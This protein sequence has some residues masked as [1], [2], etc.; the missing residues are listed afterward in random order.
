MGES[1]YDKFQRSRPTYRRSVTRI[2][3]RI[4]EAAGTTPI[5]IARRGYTGLLRSLHSASYEQFKNE[6]PVLR[7]KDRLRSPQHARFYNGF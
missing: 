4:N 2:Y 5:A 6:L 7:Y 3:A 1:S